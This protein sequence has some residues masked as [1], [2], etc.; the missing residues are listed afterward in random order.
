LLQ[1]GRLRQRSFK[2][3]STSKPPIRVVWSRWSRH[4]GALLDQLQRLEQQR[5]LRRMVHNAP[6]CQGL[7]C[8][9]PQTCPS[10]PRPLMSVRP[11]SCVYICSTAPYH[12]LFFSVPERCCTTLGMQTLAISQSSATS[13]L[14]RQLFAFRPQC[15]CAMHQGTCKK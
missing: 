13:Q 1:F 12:L 4:T 3:F 15:D 8:Q 2:F 9:S 10:L 6:L 7:S 11:T 14:P 5:H